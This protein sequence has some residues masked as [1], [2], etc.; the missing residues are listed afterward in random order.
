MASFLCY[1][2]EVATLRR[3]HQ[4]TAYRVLRFALRRG[5]IILLT[6]FVGIFITVVAANR[7]GQ[8]EAALDEQ[9]Y[10]EAARAYRQSDYWHRGIDREERN[11]YIDPAYEY[12][13]EQAGLNLPY[14]PRHLLWTWKALTFQWGDVQYLRFSALGGNSSDAR[15]VGAAIVSRVPNTLLLIGPAN[16][17]VFVIG[18]PFALFISRNLGGRLDRFFA[19][20]SPLSSVP[21]WVVG[22]ILVL[23]FAIQVHWL[24]IGGK[25][26]VVV[27]L[28]P[29]AYT[30]TV[31]KHMIL[32]VSAIVLSL[33]FQFVYAW[34]SYFLVYA[35]EDYV[36]LARARGLDSRALERRHILRP[37]LP[38][39]ITSFSLSLVTFWQ[40]TM[41]LE[42]VF[43]WPGIGKLYI[44]SLPNFW[45][46][47]LFPGDLVITIALVTIF[48]YLLGFTII[49][50]EILYALVDPRVQVG[51]SNLSMAPRRP[52]L[53]E[54]I[55]G[56]REA[57]RPPPAPR[58]FLE[59]ETIY[60]L[61]PSAETEV[62]SDLQLS[63]GRVVRELR[64]YPSAIVGLVIIGLLMLGSIYAVLWLPY[65]EVG[66]EWY[67]SSATGST[68][69]P[70]TAMPEWTN[71][72]RGEPLL[73][74]LI[75]DSRIPQPEI[76]Q[77]FDVDPS[78][79]ISERIVF[80]FDYDYAMIPEEAFVY[81]N[82][83]YAEKRPFVFWTLIK[84]DGHEIP[85]DGVTP[86]R[87]QKVELEDYVFSGPRDRRAAESAYPALTEL[88][89]HQQA[90]HYLFADLEAEPGAPLRGQYQLVVDGLAFEA[91]SWI[92]AEL[93]LLGQV[94]GPAGTD[95]RRRD[96][97]I[98]LMWG[99]PFAMSV[100]L[101]GALFTVSVSLFA[102][103]AGVWVGGKVD[104]LVQRIS[105]VNMVLPILAISVIF[106]VYYGLNLWV[107]LGI[108][109]LFGAFGSPTKTFR[110][111]FLQIKQEP[112][113]E[114]AR[115]Y[116]AS[117]LRI[118]TRYMIPKIMPVLI[119]Q[120]ITL[121]PGF[122]FLEATMGLFN[123]R[124]IYPTWGKVIYEALKHGISW[125]SRF[126][127]LEPLA[128]LL[129]TGLAFAMIGFALDRIF[130]PRQ[131][132]G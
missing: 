127:V 122:V 82:T 132:Y 44:D 124:S 73:S 84:P 19:L 62:Q 25:T 23:I 125:G 12:M 79:V 15:S 91:D 105:D 110:A 58:P 9:V 37:T 33:L 27:D 101:F 63:L 41:A 131:D 113:I 21:S 38:Y 78:G 115:A 98:P 87:R 80:T 56:W 129:L 36:E 99:M 34:R 116:G 32:P 75:Y 11:A 117:N 3:L 48:A 28:D 111:A 74:R 97:L 123:I 4:S 107:V 118:V 26:G 35:D 10:Q 85:L 86:L 39:I 24:P 6:I 60:E 119:P 114:A 1:H 126:W 89:E 61:P 108:I 8:I 88:N 103:A 83:R 72:F 7:S 50:L 109:V 130:N 40:T 18:L 96:L 52:S 90:L 30:L 5:L 57:A 47:G 2:F 46:E 93:V 13:A 49:V 94:H 120:L 29:T 92:E 45:G 16:F 66:L 71:L 70:K 100:G 76:S 112:Y 22:L 121:V 20:L 102:A 68:Y 95:I 65:G 42:V 81:F 106:Y 59:T 43:N 77:S 64:R 67:V 69:A 54:R 31:L 14:L 55:R 17:L 104:G 51:S 53:L 128:L